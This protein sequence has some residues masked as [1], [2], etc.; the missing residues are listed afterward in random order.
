[1]APNLQKWRIKKML[2]KIKIVGKV[3]NIV[4]KEYDGDKSWVYQFL[5]KKSNGEIEMIKISTKQEIK[6]LEVNK[7]AEIAVALGIYNGQITY[8]VI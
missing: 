4:E 6:G 3:Q 5:V 2:S 7:D 1:L 8:K